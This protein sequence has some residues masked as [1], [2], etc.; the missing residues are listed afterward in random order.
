VASEENS[1]QLTVAVTGPTGT[2]GF[3]LIP[4][5]QDSPRVS[6]IVGIARRAFDP[7]EHGWSKMRYRQG[8]V[9]D[10]RGLRSAFRGADVV[11]HLAFMITGN[12]SPETI[13]QI[14]VEGTLNAFRAA[15]A[16]GAARFVYA[17]SVAAYGFHPDNPLGITEEWPTRPAER[18][19]Y[20][21]EKAELEQLLAT[22]AAGGEGPEL[23]LVRPP[24][25][26][27]PH[28]LGAKATIPAPLAEA[29]TRLLELI[30]SL[31]IPIPALAPAFQ[32]QLIHEDDVGQA[33]LL[34]ALGAGPP[35]AYNIAGDG[36]LTGAD[37]ARE[38]GLTPIGIPS[39]LVKR[40]A[41]LAAALPRPPGT[42]PSLD[43]IEALAHPSI[44]DTAR[45]RREL[46]WEPRYTGL[47][48]LRATLPHRGGPEM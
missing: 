28:A 35:G 45:A 18:L 24:I 38:A 41:R 9:R 5:L 27:G 25:V 33:L 30:R 31:P 21:R 40:F 4:L 19:F 6:R 42:P 34:C 3:G 47:E 17:S 12:A 26:V 11:I 23:Y 43:W 15:R 39:A 29:G 14:N 48:A 44:M 32:L 46:G 20:A 2:F 37:I 36:V 22:E 1:G 8:D 13:R 10:E 7:A 16:V